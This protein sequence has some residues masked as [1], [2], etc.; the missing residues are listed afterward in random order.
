MPKVRRLA[1]RDQDFGVNPWQAK[2]VVP[3]DEV[4]KVEFVEWSAAADAPRKRVAPPPPDQEDGVAL[5]ATGGDAEW[6]STAKAR[7]APDPDGSPRCGSEAQHCCMGVCHGEWR[8]WGP[9][10]VCAWAEAKHAHDC[11]WHAC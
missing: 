8:R 3:H 1:G 2:E 7:A 6:I 10:G 9:A 5:G 11:A 4:D